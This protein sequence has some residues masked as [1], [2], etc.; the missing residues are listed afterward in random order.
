MPEKKGSDIHPIDSN[1]TSVSIPL[2]DAT[3]TLSAKAGVWEV[4]RK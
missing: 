2:A 1:Q 3:L 4:S